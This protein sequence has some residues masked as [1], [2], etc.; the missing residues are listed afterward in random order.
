[1]K[2][3]KVTDKRCLEL[4]RIVLEGIPGIKFDMEEFRSHCGTAGCLAGYAVA[5]YEP[6]LWKAHEFRQPLREIDSIE[7]AATRLLGLSETQAAEMFYPWNAGT[8]ELV[9]GYVP[10]ASEITPEMA[11]RMLTHFVETKSVVWE[12]QS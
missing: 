2:D 11:A 8:Y 4:S 9:T 1:M 10:E 12:R 7:S 3:T 6:E 5:A